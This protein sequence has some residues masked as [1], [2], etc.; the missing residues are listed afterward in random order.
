MFRPL[1]SQW[2]LSAVLLIGLVTLAS[3]AWAHRGFSGGHWSGGHGYSGHGYYG[4]HSYYRPY[5]DGH[6]YTPRWHSYGVPYGY[7]VPAYG[8]TPYPPPYSYPATSSDYARAR[9]GSGG[10][11]R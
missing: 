4:G 5:Y 11:C 6:S 9:V 2:F 8:G 10:G 1:T 3:P 7:S